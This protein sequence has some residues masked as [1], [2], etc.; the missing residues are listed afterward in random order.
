[1]ADAIATPSLSMM[2]LTVLFRKL[3]MIR[4]Y[5]VFVLMRRS[6][7]EVKRM[8]SIANSPVFSSFA[9]TMSGLA[10]VVVACARLDASMV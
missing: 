4:Y 9:E 6:G 10:Y 1:M 2:G 7:V 8:E 5:R 3:C